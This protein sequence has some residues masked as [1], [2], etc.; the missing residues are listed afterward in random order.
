MDINYLTYLH[1]S[2]LITNPPKSLGSLLINCLQYHSNLSL[3]LLNKHAPV[4]I[5]FSSRKSKFNHWITSTFRSFKSKVR[6]AENI[7]KPQEME[8]DGDGWRVRKSD[9][10]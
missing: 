4:I 3:S 2:E 8:R 9:N 7:W 6:H 10:R 1:C 5:K